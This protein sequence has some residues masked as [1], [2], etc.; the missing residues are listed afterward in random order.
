M[1][2]VRNERTGW[3]D[4][5][6]SKWHRKLGWNC[7][8]VDID[9]LLLEYDKGKAC[10]LIEYKN[11]HAALQCPSHPT[12]RAMIDLGNRANLPVMAV[13]YTSDYKTFKVIPLNGVAKELLPERK[14]MEEKEYVTFLYG[15]RGR[16]VPDDV[17]NGLDIVI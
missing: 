17:L 15:I 4:E 9:F 1:P 13:R 14:V 6:I 10:A 16:K 2:D 8:A 3:R 7:P 11:E 12:Y 5:G